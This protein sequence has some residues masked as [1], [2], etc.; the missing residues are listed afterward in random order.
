M[1]VIK[2]NPLN[3]TLYIKQDIEIQAEKP[4]SK[5]KNG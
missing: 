3:I 4:E 2:K 1:L 5:S